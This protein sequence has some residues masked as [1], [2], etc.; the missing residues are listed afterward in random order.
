[1]DLNAL[2]AH[3]SPTVTTRSPEL[4]EDLRAMARASEPRSRTRRPVRLALGAGIA[5]GVL[6]LGIVGA[7]A[8]INDGALWFTNTSTG[9]TCEMEFGRNEVPMGNCI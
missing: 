2:L 6:G 4:D 5:A 3:S 8:V 7:A 9:D 1:M